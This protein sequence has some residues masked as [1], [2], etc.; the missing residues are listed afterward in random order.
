[1]LINEQQKYHTIP[2][3]NIKIVKRGK[4]NIFSIQLHERSF[5]WIGT[6]TSIK[7]GGLKLV[8]GHNQLS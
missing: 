2:K 5:S 1:L 4:I 3:S 6:D 7:G 8:F